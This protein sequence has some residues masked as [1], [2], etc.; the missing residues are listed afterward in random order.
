[1]C[2]WK[3]VGV[4]VAMPLSWVDSNNLLGTALSPEPKAEKS[5]PGSSLGM[6]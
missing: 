5:I 2:K 1:M 4:F 3:E 6:A